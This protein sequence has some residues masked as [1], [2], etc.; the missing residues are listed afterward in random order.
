MNLYYI[1]NQ[2]I[3]KTPHIPH[4]RN[5]F[6]GQEADNEV[7]GSGACLSAEFWQYDSRLGRRWNV[8][9]VFKEYESPYACFAGNPIII[10]DKFG[11]DTSFSDNQAR[12]DFMKAYN[13]VNE[14]I[15]EITASITKYENELSTGTLTKFQTKKI[16]NAKTNAE[17]D[18]AEWNKLKTDFENIFT[19]KVKFTYTSEINDL[20]EN[21]NGKVLGD[22]S[23]TYGEGKEMTGVVYIAIRPGFDAFIIHENRHLN[24]HMSNNIDRPVFEIEKEAYIYQR[25]YS[26]DSVQS[27][28]ENAKK[29]Q[30]PNVLDR[31]D[32]YDLDDAIRFL[33]K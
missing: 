11:A 7:Y 23:K 18:L 8:D 9:P 30:Y 26:Y 12:Q 3:N 31:P 22:K 16:S 15:N 33:Y 13:T 21:E 25:I 5:L 10:N 28:I 4:Y 29:V 14:T 2:R 19:S 1:D 20:Q 27:I 17:K 24:Q 6:N 32:Y